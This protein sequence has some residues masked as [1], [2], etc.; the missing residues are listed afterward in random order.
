MWC[1]PVIPGDT[2]IYY[3]FSE[4]F[5][6]LTRSMKIPI[7]VPNPANQ[8][9]LTQRIPEARGETIRGSTCILG[10]SSFWPHERGSGM[11]RVLLSVGGL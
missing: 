6:F 4:F 5:R 1:K 11:I 2:I 3:L 9:V 7:V 10:T 8:E